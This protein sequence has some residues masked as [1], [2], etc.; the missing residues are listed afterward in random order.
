MPKAKNGMSYWLLTDVK[1]EIINSLGS[2]G[3]KRA[4]RVLEKY[5]KKPPTNSAVPTENV[6]HALFQITGKSYK[7]KDRDGKMK[8]FQKPVSLNAPSNK[9]WQLT[10][11]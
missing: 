5:L 11:R 6:A 7:Y 8:L 10:A 3:D 4:G 2:I 9:L 1:G